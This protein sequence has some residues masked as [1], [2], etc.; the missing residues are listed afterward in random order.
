MKSGRCPDCIYGCK[1]VDVLFY[2][3]HGIPSMWTS[4][5]VMIHL[6]KYH[7]WL[8]RKGK[9]F[10]LLEFSLTSM[11]FKMQMPTKLIIKTSTSSLETVLFHIRTAPMSI[12]TIGNP[13]PSNLF[14]KQQFDSAFTFF[15]SVSQFVHETKKV[16]TS[17]K[18]LTPQKRR[19]TT[20]LSPSTKRAALNTQLL[21]VVDEVVQD[22]EGLP[23][24]VTFLV[25]QGN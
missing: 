4:S 15:G 5:L 19:P 14:S 9:G 24:T 8:R 10:L 21:S 22:Q 2:S 7:N 3:A 16:V 6:F 18:P 1:F 12:S 13:N 20:A 17:A 11:V 23:A 25:G